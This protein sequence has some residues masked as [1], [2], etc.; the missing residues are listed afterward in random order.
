MKMPWK[1]FHGCGLDAHCGHREPELLTW[2]AEQLQQMSVAQIP[3][4]RGKQPARA[5]KTVS[6]VVPVRSVPAVEPNPV[7]RETQRPLF[8]RAAAMQRS[9]PQ[10]N[11][12]KQAPGYSGLRGW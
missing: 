8:S 5:I 12:V 7:H 10:Q 4:N 6:D 1:C 11:A 3:E 2:W 9:A